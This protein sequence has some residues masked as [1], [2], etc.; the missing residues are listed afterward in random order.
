MELARLK[1]ARD[2]CA[3]II[4]SSGDQ[5]KVYLPIFSRLEAEIHALEN[6]ESAFEKVLRISTQFGTQNGTQPP[7][8]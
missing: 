8:F 7:S 5:G 6:Q 4:A 1:N 3:W 2:K